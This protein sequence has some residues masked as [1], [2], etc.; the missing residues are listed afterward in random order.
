MVLGICPAASADFRIK[1]E[2]GSE[3]FTVAAKIGSMEAA[4]AAGALADWLAE[5]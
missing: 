5:A 4:N 1:R 2:E 3:A